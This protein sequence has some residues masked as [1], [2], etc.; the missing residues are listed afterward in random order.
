MSLIYAHKPTYD[1]TITKQ[2]HA[3]RPFPLVRNGLLAFFLFQEPLKGVTFLMQPT[4]L[5]P[6]G[7]YLV[8]DYENISRLYTEASP[9][10]ARDFP[11]P[12]L[13]PRRHPALQSLLGTYSIPDRLPPW[14]PACH[15]SLIK[16]CPCIAPLA[17]AI[18]REE[19]RHGTIDQ[20]RWKAWRNQDCELPEASGS[21][22]REHGPGLYW[23]LHELLPTEQRQ[24]WL[25]RFGNRGEKETP[26]DLDL[27]ITAAPQWWLNMSNGRGWYSCMGKSIDRDPR[28]LGNWYDT[29][30]ALAAL[31]AREANCW[32]PDCLIARTT[33]RLVWNEAPS[34]DEA[35][36]LH[37]PTSSPRIVLGRTYHNDLTSACNLLAALSAL[38]EQQQLAWGCIGGTNTAQY[39]H[40]GLLGE[41]DVADMERDLFGVPFWRPARIDEP[42]LDGDAAFR[43]REGREENGAWTYPALSTVL[44]H[45]RESAL[46]C[47]S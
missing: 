19:F 7:L 40:G 16:G 18:N 31:V 22:W 26:A 35:G 5:F 2:Q 8:P 32:T 29:G 28:I 9:D 11:L 36:S 4:T 23:L 25:E 33:V 47:H 46:S 13:L 20:Q 39:A 12:S 45:L 38:F 30:V 24:L 34:W 41:L 6:F 37:M 15:Q 14:W 43:E 42:Y 17:H 10:L 3:R 44:C 1:K 21:C 27:V